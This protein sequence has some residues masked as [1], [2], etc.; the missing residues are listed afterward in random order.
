MLL[1]GENQ[2]INII[3]I[4]KWNSYWF[5]LVLEPDSVHIVFALDEDLRWMWKLGEILCVFNHM[6]TRKKSEKFSFISQVETYKEPRPIRTFGTLLVSHNDLK[7]SAVVGIVYWMGL[8]LR[9]RNQGLGSVVAV[10]VEAEPALPDILLL[11]TCCR[12]YR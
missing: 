11:M 3:L 2:E 8:Q 9:Q 12:S 5:P 7:H 4:K 6:I 10:E 1:K